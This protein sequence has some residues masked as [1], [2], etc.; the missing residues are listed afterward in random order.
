MG[1][2]VRLTRH[3]NTDNQQRSDEEERTGDP[4]NKVTSSDGTT[5]AYDRTGA[6]PAVVLV[7]GAFSERQHPV[8]AQLAAL[9]SEDYTVYNY[10]RR[11]RGDSGDTA[12]Y[13]VEREIEDLDAVIGGAGGSA[14]VFGLS[15]GAALALEG[16]ARGLNITK[17]V[18]YDPPYVP[19]GFPRPPADFGSQLGELVA[20]GKRGEAVEVFMTK[21][22]GMPV[23]FVAP[24][25]A[26]PM[27]PGLE[28]LAH[29][30][31]YD[32]ALLG[33]GSV[34]TE[35]ITSIA[36]PT[37]VVNAGTTPPMAPDAIAA[38]IAGAQRRTLQD[39]SHDVSPDA[40]AP[41]LKE[42]FAG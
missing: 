34:P 10:D 26:A 16:A 19:D 28:S 12:P 23:E 7:G 18:A 21:G 24:M 2:Q 31:P 37:L 15:S 11:G 29:T 35:R 42:F 22:M 5:I 40:I 17:L 8:M 41:V 1:D 4:V 39:Q 38:A 9:M 13:A 25:R 36:A 3:G 32:V 6:G 30:L 14:A 33:D 20:A 27:W